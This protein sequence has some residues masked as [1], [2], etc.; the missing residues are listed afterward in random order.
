V[1]EEYGVVEVAALGGRHRIGLGRE[2]WEWARRVLG[3]RE[4]GELLAEIG[5]DAA[6]FEDVAR[7]VG[8]LAEHVFRGRVRTELH[9]GSWLAGELRYTLLVEGLAGT[10]DLILSVG[11][12]PRRFR[13]GR[14]GLV[15]LGSI[16]LVNRVGA[17]EEGAL[18]LLGLFFEELADLLGD[19][20][21]REEMRREGDLRVLY[22]NQR[23]FPGEEGLNPPR[24]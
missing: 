4:F 13:G 17:G 6:R 16:M 20:E 11:V 23:R 24:G 8:E 5:E 18:R 3:P 10:V 1:D 9:G 19:P 14:E 21:I 22:L 12:L 7:V 2:R 15:Y